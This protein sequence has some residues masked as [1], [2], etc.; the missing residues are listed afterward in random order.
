VR[1]DESVRTA[2]RQG[3]G[4]RA[5]RVGPG[6]GGVVRAGRVVDV[7]QRRLASCVASRC[8]GKLDSDGGS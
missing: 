7:S 5:G 8:G 2:V 6:F 4:V 1:S 3:R